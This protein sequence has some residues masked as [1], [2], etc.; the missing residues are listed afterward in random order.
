MEKIKESAEFVLDFREEAAA[1][2]V[3]ELR[4][5]FI[6]AK[7]L[8]ALPE[9]TY[10]DDTGNNRNF[11][12]KIREVEGDEDTGYLEEGLVRVLAEVI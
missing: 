10:R 8:K 12:V 9:F 6:T 4:A 7:G 3:E 5:A 2:P 1:L 11:F